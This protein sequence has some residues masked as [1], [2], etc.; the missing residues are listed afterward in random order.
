M[1]YYIA[2][3]IIVFFE[4]YGTMDVRVEVDECQGF[5][6]TNSSVAISSVRFI[7]VRGKID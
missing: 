7:F 3:I 5:Y 1:I 4:N 2:L 6:V